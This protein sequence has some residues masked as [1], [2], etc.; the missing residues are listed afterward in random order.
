MPI[1]GRK[2]EKVASDL[3]L[4]RGF[5]QLI[6]FLPHLQQAIVMPIFGRKSEKVASDLGLGR[7]FRQLIWFL[8]HLQQASHAYIRQRKLPVTWG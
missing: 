7:G 3:G 4:G 8:P 5:R 1:F 2:S 6:W